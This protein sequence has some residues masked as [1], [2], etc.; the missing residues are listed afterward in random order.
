MWQ[1]EFEDYPQI[2]HLLTIELNRA[3]G[4]WAARCTRSTDGGNVIF[5]L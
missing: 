4:S 2:A 3:M 5:A 1:R